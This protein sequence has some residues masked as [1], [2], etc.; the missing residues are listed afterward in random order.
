MPTRPQRI[1]PRLAVT[2]RDGLGLV[3]DA[4]LNPED[5]PAPAVV[6]RTPYGRNVPTLLRL[7]QKLSQEGVCAVLQDCRGRYQSPG[8]YD[9][10]CEED[11]TYDT[12]RW[13][14]EQPWSNGRVGLVGMSVT[15][16]PNCFVAGSPPPGVEVAAM[17]SVMGSISHHAT[18]YSGG[19]LT[20]HWAL[21]WSVM[22]DSRHMGR[23]TWQKLPWEEVFRRLPLRDATGGHIEAPELW[24]RMA[25]SAAYDEGWARFDA[26]PRLERL[27]V[28]TLHL[29]GWLDFMLEQ[30]LGSFA[31]MAAA[32]PPGRQRLI[33]GT[34]D[35]GSLFESFGAKP[36]TPTSG[37]GIDL[38]EAIVAWFRRWLLAAGEAAD[39]GPPVLLNVQEDA[40]WIGTTAYPPAEAEV[41]AWYLTSGGRAGTDPEDGAL[42]R[43]PPGEVKCDT[44]AYD[45]EAPVPT[46]GGALWPFPAGGLVPGPLDQAE[47]E[48]RPDVLVYTSAPL[49]DDLY[50]VGP[51]VV[52]LWAS[53]S[54]RDTDFTAK[55]V[56]V[57]ALGAPRI[58]Q[59]GIVRG[60]FHRSLSAAGAAGAGA[61]EEP[62]EPHRPYNF[63]ISLPGTARR[64]RRG[65][66]LRLEIASSNFPKFDRNLNTMAPMADAVVGMVV[67]QMVFHGGY[68][69]S[70]IRLSVIP[71]ERVEMLRAAPST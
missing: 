37:P 34:W 24:G 25:S 32:S 35:H 26:R 38:L 11:D 40:S 18:V 12:L 4:F 70:R 51:V 44:F 47:V 27:T 9:W 50:V 13:V 39:A 45:P 54:A 55:L 23:N 61:A 64:F 56:D 53:T 14:A 7:A 31:I 42:V 2:T 69:A 43:E 66:R 5:G 67:Q 58:V 15:S 20:L 36:S 16:N 17:V 63:T 21:P 48:R 52:D 22:M 8:S 49:D 68:M 1:L 62:L 10:A 60:R 30:T 29:S 59:D 46:V 33:V 65:H 71:R 6:L 19:A 28:P 3:T 57:D 41:V